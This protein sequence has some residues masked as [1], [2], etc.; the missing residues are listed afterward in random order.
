MRLSGTR[1]VER[2]TG[3][4]IITD[5]PIWTNRNLGFQSRIPQNK[6]MVLEMFRSTGN[7][8]VWSGGWDSFCFCPF[9]KSLL[10]LEETAEFC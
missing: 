1:L 9:K 6:I 3:H 5:T 2:P 10:K 4:E 7:R 8:F